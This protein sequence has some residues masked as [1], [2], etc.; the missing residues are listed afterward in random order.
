MTST[1]M[2][3][4]FIPTHIFLWIVLSNGQLTCKH[5]I[6]KVTSIGKI[7]LNSKNKPYDSAKDFDERDYGFLFFPS[8]SVSLADEQTVRDE[9]R[10]FFNWS[11][12]NEY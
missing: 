12:L 10:G 7:I 1:T 11:L 3:L 6:L 8:L 5:N 2:V 9:N 4:P